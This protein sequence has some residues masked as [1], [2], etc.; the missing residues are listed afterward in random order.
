MIDVLFEDEDILAVDKPEGL[1]VVPERDI[2]RPCLKAM[3]AQQVPYKPYVVHRL[4]KEVSGV[5]LLAKNAQAHRTLNDQFNTHQV[6]KTYLALVHGGMEQD[7]GTIDR[8]IREF[9]SGRMGIDVQRGKPSVTKYKVLDRLAGYTLLEAHPITGRRHQ[10][11]V[12]LYSI[13]HPIVGDI[14]YGDKALQG[15]FGR[16]ML[17]A[18]KVTFTAPSG[19]KR[20]IGSPVPESFKQVL[21]ALG[22]SPI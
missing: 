15:L 20:A 14:H 2:T 3:L 17:H 5:M 12:H 8:P 9:G 21:E 1:A 10:I 18:L 19:Q 4:D 6:H 13:G 22:H 11:R 16:L 7:E